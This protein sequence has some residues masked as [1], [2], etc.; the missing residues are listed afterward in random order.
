[1]QVGWQQSAQVAFGREG[2]GLH[3]SQ[4]GSTPSHL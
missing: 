4:V 3:G 1:M 2:Q